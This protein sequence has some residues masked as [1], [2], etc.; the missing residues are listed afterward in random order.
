MKYIFRLFAALFITVVY[1]P[2][3]F[4]L[5]FLTWLT[6]MLWEIKYIDYKEVYDETF[7]HIQI[8]RYYDIDRKTLKPERFTKCYANPYNVLINKVTIFNSEGEEVKGDND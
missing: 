1:Y 2:I 6:W 4:T 7:F 8:L 3:M 5:Y